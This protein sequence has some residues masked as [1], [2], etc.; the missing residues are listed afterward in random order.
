MARDLGLQEADLERIE[1]DYQGMDERCYQM[2][3]RWEQRFTGNGCSCQTL[4]RVLLDSDKNRHLFAEY[5]ERAK[6]LQ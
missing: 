2:L 1:S 3:L 4:G 6:K 5:V